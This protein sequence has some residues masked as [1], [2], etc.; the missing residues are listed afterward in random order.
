MGL[1]V[2]PNIR[3]SKLSSND[4]VNQAETSKSMEINNDLY[5][6]RKEIAVLKANFSAMRQKNVELKRNNS[7]LQ[8]INDKL[9]D[10]T[11][12]SNYSYTK[13]VIQSPSSS[14]ETGIGRIW[15]LVNQ[16]LQTIKSF[17]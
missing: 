9:K 8:T 10:I 3:S 11:L 1:Q 5:T 15:L 2:K 13:D 12:K 17:V 4:V 14:P 16:N 6:L 7:E